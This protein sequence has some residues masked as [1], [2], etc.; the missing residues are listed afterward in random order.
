MKLPDSN[1]T[2]IE[3]NNDIHS[4]TT[5]AFDVWLGSKQCTTNLTRQFNFY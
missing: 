1:W 5:F 2:L 3:K 4:K